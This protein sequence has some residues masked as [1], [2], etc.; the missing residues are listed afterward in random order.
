LSIASGYD[1]AM[2]RIPP[3]GM[4]FGEPIGFGGAARALFDPALASVGRRSPRSL[5][6]RAHRR[7]TAPCVLSK[8]GL[9]A[10]EREDIIGA[11]SA[12]RSPSA[13]PWRSPPCFRDD[14]QI[15]ILHLIRNSMDFASWKDR[16]PPSSKRAD[17]ENA[18]TR[19]VR[20]Q[21]P[22][23]HHVRRQVR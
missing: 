18:A 11:L 15:C 7:R 14:V 9:V 19:M 10:F 20:G 21:G 12:G 23:R 3:I 4:A 22:I 5:R 17:M 1:A 6:R 16:K 2:E 8:A 13:S